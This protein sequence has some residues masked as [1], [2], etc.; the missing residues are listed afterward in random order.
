MA[1]CIASS[2]SLL[3]S[4]IV[5]NILIMISGRAG[6]GLPYRWRNVLCHQARC[7]TRACGDLGLDCGMV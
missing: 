7:P 3:S 6:I 4:R 1:M 5:W 2:G